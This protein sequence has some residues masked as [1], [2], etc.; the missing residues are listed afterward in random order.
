MLEQ[1]NHLK[2]DTSGSIFPTPPLQSS[3][4]APTEGLICQIPH[5]PDTENAWGL[6]GEEGGMLKFLFWQAHNIL[7]DQIAWH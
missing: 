4:S 6:P 7:N 1:K 3:N 5:S 2:L